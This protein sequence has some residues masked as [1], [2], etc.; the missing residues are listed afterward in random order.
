M[1]EDGTAGTLL[2]LLELL[3]PQLGAIPVV[4]YN[5]S[6]TAFH[7]AL[8]VRVGNNGRKPFYVSEVWLCTPDRGQSLCVYC[9]HKEPDQIVERGGKVYSRDFSLEEVAPY[10]RKGSF[11]EMTEA[12]GKKHT[13]RLK[14]KTTEFFNGDWIREHGLDKAVENPPS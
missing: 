10:A 14:D 9:E 5:L 12:T 1:A 4:D 11:I 6:Y 3:I 13:K 7:F 2:K 8:E